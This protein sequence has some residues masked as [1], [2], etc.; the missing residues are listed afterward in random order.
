MSRLPLQAPSVAKRI[1]APAQRWK[2]R[3]GAQL[4]SV[5]ERDLGCTACLKPWSFFRPLRPPPS[6]QLQGLIQ[7]AVSLGKLVAGH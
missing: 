1:T 3:G 4:S 5:P 7:S 2:V 6:P